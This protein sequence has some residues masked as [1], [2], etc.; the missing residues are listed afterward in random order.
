MHK[1]LTDEISADYTK[2]LQ[3]VQEMLGEE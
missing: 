2:K 3:V 1:T